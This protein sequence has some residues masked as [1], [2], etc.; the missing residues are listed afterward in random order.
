ML[1]HSLGKDGFDESRALRSVMAGQSNEIGR[2]FALSN[3]NSRDLVN[4]NGKGKLMSY[5]WQS[6]DSMMPEIIDIASSNDEWQG[7]SASMYF[8]HR[9]QKGL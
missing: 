1:A 8:L 2:S 7:K 3:Y 6:S 5:L 9:K 4:D